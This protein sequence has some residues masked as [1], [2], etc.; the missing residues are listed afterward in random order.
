MECA[1]RFVDLLKSE[2]AR[3]QVV[4]I[5]DGPIASEAESLLQPEHN[6]ETRNRSARSIER[7]EA[8]DLRHVLLRR[9]WQDRDVGRHDMVVRHVP[10]RLV[11]DADGMSVIGHVSGDFSQMLGR[12]VGITPG[13][14]QR[15][16]FAELGADG[17]LDL[18]LSATAI[19]P[20]NVAIS[21][22][23]WRVRPRP[24]SCRLTNTGSCEPCVRCSSW[25]LTRCG[26]ASTLEMLITPLRACTIFPKKESYPL[27][28][29][30]VERTP[31]RG[32]RA[33]MRMDPYEA[34]LLSSSVSCCLTVR[35]NKRLV[36][37][38]ASLGNRQISAQHL[39]ADSRTYYV[40]CC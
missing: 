19:S 35:R 40:L 1:S 20:G 32:S 5:V 26:E 4:L 33:T 8:A 12:S 7:S 16:R 23:C 31:R 13:H 38:R 39:S 36:R 29:E 30:R 21:L 9:Q 11:H 14:N 34:F 37:A 24:V 22:S 17:H 2:E 3:E 15:G 27:A 28:A 6:L 10:S 25:R 18:P